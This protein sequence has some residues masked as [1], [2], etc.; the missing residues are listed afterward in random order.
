[1]FTLTVDSL[2]TFAET[3]EATGNFRLLARFLN[4]QALA[5]LRPIL[6]FKFPLDAKT[7]GNLSYSPLGR[8]VIGNVGI[9]FQSTPGENGFHALRAAVINAAAKAGPEGW[10]ILDVMREFPANS[11]SVNVQGLRDLQREL[12]IYLSYNRAAVE[13]IRAQANAEAAT[14]ANLDVATLPDLSQPGPYAFTQTT[15]TVTNPALRQT[16]QGLSVNYDFDVDVYLP[17]KLSGPAPV[18]IVSH[19]FGAVKEDFI[20]L[21]RHL[22][23]HGYVVVA[24]DHVGS[25]LQYR[26]E[27]L[28]GRLN[29]L[30]SPIEFVNRPQE[31][32]FLIDELERLVASSPDWA[33]RLDLERIGAIGDSLGSSTVMA[34]A[35]ADINR[36]R[37]VET[38][39]RDTLS[40]NFALY[41]ECRARFLP[42]KNFDLRDPRIKAII[43][44]HNMG[45]ALYGPESIAKINVPTLMVTG[46]ADVTSPVVTEQFAPFIWLQAEPRYLVLLQRGTHFSS[47]PPGEGA[48]D[49]PGILVG[50]HRE[51]GSAYYKT[52]TVAFLGAHLQGQE[53]YLPYLSASYAKAI[54]EGQP[55]LMDII[56]N[57]TGAQ[58]NAAYPGTPPVALVPPPVAPP[59]S[60]EESILTAIERTGELRIA[61]RRDAP[62]FGYLDNDSGWTGYCPALA[63]ALRDYLQ[64]EMS[65]E[66]AIELVE[67]PSTLGDRFDLVRNGQVYLECGPNSLQ[68]GLEGIEFSNLIFATGSRFLTTT[69][70]A[71]TVNPALSL[72]GLNLG[73]LANS[74]NEAF[75]QERYPTATITRFDGPSGRTDAIQAVSNGQLDA[76]LGDDILTLAEIEQLGLPAQTLTLVP[77]I[78]LTCE[79]YSLALPSHDPAWVATV[80]TFLSTEAGEDT[81]S[82][83]LGELAPGYVNTLAYCLNR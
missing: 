40:L 27:F 9:V 33:A 38:C 75:L 30:L 81:W 80:N 43:S 6:Q 26:R 36:A 2:E 70:K 50:E 79:Y 13:A 35:G 62:P 20:F 4:E 78:P 44:A 61:M 7:V 66:V 22:A 56:T 49:V 37:I 72:E 21:N 64:E 59:S 25:D 34:L 15:I 52:L 16:Q 69:A 46:S 42:P 39:D 77:E 3:G 63:I 5:G 74:T 19:G 17:E 82:T 65:A 58:V 47:K 76:F 54:S 29:T 45:A 51:V 83:W 53:Q 48:G 32:S 10:T 71:P 67:L 31:I 12:A 60:R 8:D 68:E 28:G 18:V 23:S 11:I 41:L 55:M 57:L 24:P 1:V 14:Q 73:V